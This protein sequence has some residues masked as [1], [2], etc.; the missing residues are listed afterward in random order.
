MCSVSLEPSRGPPPRSPNAAY[1]M[2][3]M[4]VRLWLSGGFGRGSYS[5]LKPRMEVVKAGQQA[6]TLALQEWVSVCVCV[7]VW[8]VLCLCVYRKM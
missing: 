8:D 3:F 5:G 4:S 2:G 1:G 6:D 7:C